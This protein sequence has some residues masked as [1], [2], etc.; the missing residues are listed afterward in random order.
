MNVLDVFNV[1]HKIRVDFFMTQCFPK[2]SIL[3][4]KNP[5]FDGSY[6]TLKEGLKNAQHMFAIVYSA[7]NVPMNIAKPLSFKL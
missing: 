4:K 2:A 3:N 6:N 5:S 7:K 1:T